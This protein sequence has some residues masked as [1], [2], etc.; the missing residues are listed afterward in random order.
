[1]RVNPVRRF[2]RLYVKIAY[3]PFDST[4]TADSLALTE[5][6]RELF[7]DKTQ[8]SIAAACYQPR[9]A[10]TPRAG[11]RA[12]AARNGSLGPP[13]GMHADR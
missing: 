9:H 2:L 5:V 10:S 13:R 11:S 7:A 12:G 6:L 3:V 8:T 4:R 1:M